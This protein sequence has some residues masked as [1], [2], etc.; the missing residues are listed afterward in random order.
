MMPAPRNMESNPTLEAWKIPI[1]LFQKVYVPNSMFVFRQAIYPTHGQGEKLSYKTFFGQEVTAAFEGGKGVFQY[2]ASQQFR[3]PFSSF[4]LQQGAGRILQVVLDAKVEKFFG[5]GMLMVNETSPRDGKYFRCSLD[6]ISIIY[7]SKTKLLPHVHSD[8]SW[9]PKGTC[10]PYVF[11]KS[12]QVS[13][14]PWPIP[15]RSYCNNL[16]VLHPD[17]SASQWVDPEIG[18]QRV[19]MK[20][21]PKAGFLR[22]STSYKLL[23]DWMIGW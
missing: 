15:S 10:R 17:R 11:D 6:R 5:L 12:I 8:L 19:D 3:G 9:T 16:P 2:W 21:M 23:D 20:K 13:S 1:F 22:E 18:F 14:P 4:N 7:V